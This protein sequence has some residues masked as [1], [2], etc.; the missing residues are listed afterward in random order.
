MQTDKERA[1]P[2]EEGIETAIDGK[3]A[4]TW[5][6]LVGQIVAFDASD[7]KQTATIA[8]TIQAV[9]TAPDGTRSLVTMP[10]LLDCPVY[11]PEGGGAVLTFPIQPGDECLVV[12]ADRCIDSWWQQGGIQP[13]AEYRMHDLSDGMAY[14]GFRS[15]PNNIPGLSTTETQLRSTDG[16]TV[17]GLNPNTGSVHIDAPGNLIINADVVINGKLDV[18]GNVETPAD[19]KAGAISLKTHKH[20]GVTAGGAQTGVPA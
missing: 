3:L 7:E 17:I 8:P 19:V 12:F 14:V 5:T 13:P 6:A 4:M 9:V 1:N 18:T 10:L 2:Y 20:G 11:F 16:E 15:V